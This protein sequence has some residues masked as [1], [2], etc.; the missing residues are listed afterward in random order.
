MDWTAEQVVAGYAHQQQVERV[1]RGLKDGDRLGW[2]PIHHWTD[3][4]IHIHAFYCMLGFYL[5]AGCASASETAS[6]DLSF[7]ALIEELRQSIDSLRKS[8]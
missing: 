2:N 7:E 3:R 8:I 6:A 1:L 5:P 4:K